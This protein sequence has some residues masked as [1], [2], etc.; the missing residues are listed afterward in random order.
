[1]PQNVTDVLNLSCY[2]C[3]EPAPELGPLVPPPAPT[4]SDG[5]LALPA[6]HLWTPSAGLCLSASGRFK[7]VFKTFPL[8]E[9]FTRP[10]ASR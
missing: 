3:P 9:S 6:L 5:I 2:L 7:L 1:M 4:D 10:A 8:P